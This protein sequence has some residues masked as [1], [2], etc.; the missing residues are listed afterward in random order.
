MANTTITLKTPI[1]GGEGQIKQV[2]LR[3]PRYLDVMSLGEPAAFARSEGG[4]VFTSE[5]TDV[6]QAYIERLVVQP[7]DSALL[8]QL[9][10]ADALQLKETI[11]GFFA[12]AKPVTST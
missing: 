1:E 11:F 3:E 10:L 2:I 6:V 12:A 7:A 5:K 8:Q 4:I 9:G